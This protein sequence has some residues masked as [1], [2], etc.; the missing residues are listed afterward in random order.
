[1]LSVIDQAFAS[2]VALQRGNH[3]HVITAKR[4]RPLTLLNDVQKKS[5]TLASMKFKRLWE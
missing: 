4:E 2:K 1:M 3:R 5:P